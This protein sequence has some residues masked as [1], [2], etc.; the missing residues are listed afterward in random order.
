MKFWASGQTSPRGLAICHKYFK[1]KRIHSK[2]YFV[3]C[4]RSGAFGCSVEERVLRFG[5]FDIV[6]SNLCTVGQLRHPEDNGKFFKGEYR[7]LL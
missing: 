3:F 2:G 5:D 1:I 4:F 6:W 7:K